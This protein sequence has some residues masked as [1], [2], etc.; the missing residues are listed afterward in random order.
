[1]DVAERSSLWT[2]PAAGIAAVVGLAI[3]LVFF[4][5]GAPAL[6]DPDEPYYA[7]PAL[8]M[9]R[10]GTWA[11][12]V[13][14]GQPWF[15][16]PALYYW[17]IL[18]AF[19]AFGV[20]EWAARLGSALAGLGGAVALATLAP[21]GWRRNGAHLLA[22]IVLLT[23][24]EYAYL[25]R[26]A[27]TDMTLTMFVTLGFLA[28]ARHLETGS[29]V[30][31]F[32]SGAAFGLAVLTKG[33]VGVLVP[34]VALAA[35]GLVA[36]R[37][38]AIAF[39]SWL[40]AAAGFFATSLPWYLYMFIAHRELL[41]SVFLGEENLGRFVSAEHRQFPLFYVAVLAGGLL[42]WSAALPSSLARSIRKLTRGRERE[43]GVLGTTYAL[44]WFGAVLGIFG[45]SA[46]KLASYVL[47]AFPAAAFLIAEYWCQELPRSRRGEHAARGP[48]AVAWAGA[49]IAVAAAA[50]LTA[51]TSR[52]RF[53]TPGPAPYVIAAVVVAA[54]L[55]AVLA[56]TRGRLLW[57]A[58]LQAASSLALVLGAVV[59]VGPGLAAAESTK[60]LVE[61]LETS[62]LADEVV[63]TYRVPDV[64]LD[65]YWP[66]PLRRVTDADELTRRVATEPGR[67]WIVRAN[68]LDALAA[69]SR[70]E[71]KPLMT[72]ARRS[73][74]RLSPRTAAP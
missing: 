70:L 71:V 21:A 5:L 37:R 3:P 72:V 17:T 7:V 10:T 26:A 29:A 62:G 31:A 19:K 69:E 64:S 58:S 56:V 52:G 74:V 8:E 22:A 2:S 60:S 36:R 11:V 39:R 28:V 54:A 47:P 15:D 1:M 43:G 27:V 9:L 4:K 42:P 6:V 45:L 40:V 14:H 53:A 33:P 55:F 67:L 35:Y 46:S 61:R 73:A 51:A 59:Y 38:V 34:G 25:S 49:A 41:V 32:G 66:R 13:F 57:F 20:S 65:F 63:G 12:P 23:S 44:C 24:L 68:E 18:A 16:K 48:V 50:A 30:A